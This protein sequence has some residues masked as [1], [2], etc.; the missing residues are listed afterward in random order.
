MKRWIQRTSAGILTAAILS[1]TALA[2]NFTHCA[3]ALK[4][5]E[6]FS[7]TKHGYEL[8]RTPTRAE[9]AVMLVRLLGQEETAKSK[10][11]TIPFQDVPAWA[12]SYVGWLYENNLTV[13]MSNTKFGTTQLCSAQQYATF[14]LRTLGYAEGD[15][16]TY[17]TAL[18]YAKTLGVI[19]TANYDNKTFL[20]DHM[21]A[22]SY[23]ALSR[24]TKSGADMLL[25]ALITQGSVDHQKA[26]ETKLRF[27]NYRAY[28]QMREAEQG[29]ARAYAL[30]ATVYAPSGQSLVYT[31][32]AQLEGE[33]FSAELR[34]QDALMVGLYQ[35]DGER[36]QSVNGKTTKLSVKDTAVIPVSAILQLSEKNGVYA[37]SLVPEVIN[38]MVQGNSLKQIDYSIKTDG[39]IIGHQTARI[40]VNMPVNG[41]TDTYKI[42]LQ[43]DSVTASGAVEIPDGMELS[44]KSS[45]KEE[46]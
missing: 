6:L 2:A 17:Q 45:G 44:G 23:T 15:G 46:N 13:G 8:E 16:Y 10:D 18:D 36:Y 22:M 5:M 3:D 40:Q 38:K 24:P 39:N 41:K 34:Y 19:D 27:E 29:K 4:G 14:L 28:I 31:G 20:R 35:K 25:D 37:F 26:S 9:A 42:E 7:G 43:A 33:D 30:A 21:V 1:S 11:Y 32:K 12:A